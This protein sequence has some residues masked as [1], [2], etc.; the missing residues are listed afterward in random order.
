MVSTTASAIAEVKDISPSIASKGENSES[1]ER[2]YS[3]R[4]SE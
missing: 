1:D 3:I 4:L 2:D